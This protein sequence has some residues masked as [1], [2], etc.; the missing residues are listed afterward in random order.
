MKEVH[1]LAWVILVAASAAYGCDVREGTDA[2]EYYFAAEKVASM[3]ECCTVC[4][5]N[6]QC[7]YASF[8]TAGH[9]A[10]TCWLKD[11]KTMTPVN[12]SGVALVIVRAQPPGPVPPR[13]SPSPPAPPL[14]PPKYRVE[15]EEHS[16]KPVLSHGNAVGQGHSP[17]PLTFNPAYVPVAG[18]NTVG[19]VIV[20]TD[21]C[22]ATKGALSFAKC[23]VQTGECNDLEPAYQINGSQGTEDPRVVWDP[24]TEYFYNFAYG[25]DAKQSLADGCSTS[26]APGAPGACTVILSRSRTPY[27]ANS[28][29]HVPG[30]T[31]P[32]HRNGCCV[33]APVGQKSYCIFGES[34][35]EGPGSGLGIAYTTNISSGKF[36]QTNWTGG[37]PGVGGSGPWMQPLGAS[38]EE[39]KLEAG[40]H[41][42]TLSTGDLLHFYAAATPGWVA[43][44][45]YTAGYIILDKDEPTKI[46]QRQSGQFFVPTYDYET[47]CDGASDCP[48]SGER[49]NVIFASSATPLGGDKFR[50]FFG[51]GDGNVG[52]AIVTVSLL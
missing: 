2:E 31:Y 43:H 45:N 34:G 46:I 3:A 39:I 32:W 11:G 5:T 21:G 44:G 35:N 12:K 41:I 47:L 19:G 20:R 36:T 29:E 37:V 15:L 6:P 22:N 50:L 33:M 40:T 38:Q 27:E 14:P 1:S 24:Y 7:N 28:W 8:A 52:T 16:S 17:C 13:P 51:G 48:F 9:A 10:G 26:G 49:K 25:T 4:T 42:Q 18:G 30:G 23:D